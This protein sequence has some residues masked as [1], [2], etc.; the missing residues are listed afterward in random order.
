MKV[1]KAKR[2]KKWEVIAQDLPN[3]TQM[4]WFVLSYEF[5]IWSGN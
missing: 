3:I 2:V 4:D 1:N 5:G